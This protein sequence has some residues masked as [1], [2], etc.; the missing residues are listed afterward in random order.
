MSHAD[1]IYRELVTEIIDHGEIHENRTGVNTRRIWGSMAKF[2]LTVGFPLLTQK[3]MAVKAAFVEMLGFVRGETDVDWYEQNGCK[4]WSAD[5]AR[6][7]GKDLERDKR[8]LD[9]LMNT[10]IR[11]KALADE[12]ARLV[13][14]IEWRDFN[15]RSLG[16]IYGAQWRNFG[17]RRDG[18]DQLKDIIDQLKNGSNSRRLIM[19]AWAPHETHMMALP[20]CHIAY[21]FVKR[22]EFVDV[23]MW[24]RSCDTALGVPFNWATT[25]LLTHLVGH[26]AGLRPGRMAWFGDDVHV[27]EPHV[28]DFEQQFAQEQF[29]S[30]TLTIKAAP[31]TLPWA[32]N[33]ADLELVNYQCSEK[34]TF[35]LFVG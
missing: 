3:R 23:S 15:K 14:S 34:V 16:R 7:H 24:Q 12:Y 19:S 28:K 29:T 31:G 26:A 1:V 6:W 20:P 22:N 5:H 27:Y 35:E 21:H 10:S 25:A 13:E 9:E 8:R 17:D 2:D 33:Y 4:I 32:I 30:P 11:T 18:F